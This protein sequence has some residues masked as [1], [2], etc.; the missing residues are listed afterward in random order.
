MGSPSHPTTGN[1]NRQSANRLVRSQRLVEFLIEGTRG[2]LVFRAITYG[3][4][5]AVYA[6]A[7]PAISSGAPAPQVN[8]VSTQ[9]Q[10]TVD[11]HIISPLRTRCTSVP[12]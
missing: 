7:A 2:P 12:R 9:P 6:R 5:A 4:R 10:R 11:R 8:V 1:G 3:A